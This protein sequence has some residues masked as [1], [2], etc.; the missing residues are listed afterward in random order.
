MRN[1]DT[2]PCNMKPAAETRNGVRNFPRSE[3]LSGPSLPRK[4]RIFP[5][6]CWAIHRVSTPRSSSDRPAAVDFSA[7]AAAAQGVNFEPPVV[8]RSQPPPPG[9]Y[10]DIAQV[11]IHYTH[12]TT[13]FRS[14]YARD[15]DLFIRT[16]AHVYAYV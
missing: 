16:H 6:P 1:V 14:P 11:R 13:A 10:T 2:R 4:S 15:D 9:P 12:A 3:L 7:R 8:F 5:H